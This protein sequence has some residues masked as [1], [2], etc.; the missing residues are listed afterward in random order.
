MNRLVVRFLE[1][2]PLFF[3]AFYS[4][5][6][7]KEPHVWIASFLI[8]GVCG[9][10]VTFVLYRKKILLDRFYL[11]INLF[12]VIGAISLTFKFSSF[13]DL[14][15]SGLEQI[16]FLI[17][18]IVGLSSTILTKAGF[19]GVKGPDK[20]IRTGS[21]VLLI[22]AGLGVTLSILFPS[23]FAIGFAIPL[24]VFLAFRRIVL[25]RT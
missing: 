9:A 13:L 2:M 14:Y 6:H 21:L 11:S 18:F 15:G 24:I 23:D 7:K 3:F 8:A 25:A 12:F 10:A 22:I 5:T 17:L 1:I 4:I 20:F 19:V 16:F